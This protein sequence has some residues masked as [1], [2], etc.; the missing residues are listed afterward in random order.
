MVDFALLELLA[1]G[2]FHSGTALGERLKLSRSAIWKQMQA[3]QDYGVE[4]YS[5]RGRGYRLP[6]GLDLLNVEKLVALISLQTE[7]AL[8]HVELKTFTDSTNLMALRNIDQFRHSALY[9][10]E[11]QHAGRGRR[12]RSWQ[13]PVATNLYFSLMWRFSGGAASLQGLSLVVGLS[14]GQSLVKIGVPGVGLKWP[15][16]L[17]HKDGKLAGILLEMQGDA[18]GDVSVVIG[19]GLNVLMNALHK[20]SQQIDQPWVDL[21]SIAHRVIDRNKLLA[22]IVSQLIENMELFAQRGFSAFSE[23]W[24]KFHVY[25]DSY[26]KL[27]SGEAEIEGVCRGVNNHGALLLERYGVIEAHHGGEISV[28]KIE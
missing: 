19:V 6:N 12:G 16:D 28:R 3:L 27:I 5:V 18:S 14:V 17:M 24:H 7:Q 11:H 15:N 26:V 23:L 4:V 8:Q 21:A 10:A 13:G 22:L 20:Q 25:Q 2:E 9:L 1:D